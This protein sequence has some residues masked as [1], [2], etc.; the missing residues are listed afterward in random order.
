M[1]DENVRNWHRL[2]GSV[3]KLAPWMI[4]PLRLMVCQF[5]NTHN[6]AIQEV[7]NCNTNVQLGDPCQFFYN[8]LYVVKN[9]QDEDAER[10][11]R[12]HISFCQQLV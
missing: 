1:T 12:V 3:Q 2:D 4:L 10:Q 9:T 7:F 6:D 11:C 5:V 8:T